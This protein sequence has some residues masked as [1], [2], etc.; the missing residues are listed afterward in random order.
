MRLR[1]A[2]FAAVKSLSKDKCVCKRRPSGSNVDRS[3][4]SKVERRQVVKPAIGVPGPASNGAVDNG[5]PQEGKYQGRNDAATL[6]GSTNHDLDGASAEEKLVQA[7]HNLRDEGRTRRRR[8]LDIH[9]AEVGEVAN[10]GTGGAAVGERVTPEHPLESGDGH[11]HEGLE[12]QR[13]RRFPARETAVEQ[14]DARD[15]EEDEDAAAHQP[16]VVELEARVLDIDVDQGRV[17]ALGLGGVELRLRGVVS[18][19]WC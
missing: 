15:D 9:E 14:T 8:N 4:T 5:S 7:E 18:F 6:K 10:E 17:A 19:V 2:L 1:V 13:E 11:D 12:E 16:D 3:T